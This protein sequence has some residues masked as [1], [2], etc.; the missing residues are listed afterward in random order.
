MSEKYSPSESGT[1]L[2]APFKNRQA[3]ANIRYANA[4]FTLILSG[5]PSFYIVGARA[6]CFIAAVFAELRIKSCAVAVPCAGS[7]G[8]HLRRNKNIYPTNFLPSFAFFCGANLL[9]YIG[10]LRTY[11]IKKST[12][13]GAVKEVVY[14]FTQ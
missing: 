5:I 10:K 8:A 3:A 12:A 2:A 11:L 1:P 13:H 9:Y 4:L 14:F 7:G 6:I